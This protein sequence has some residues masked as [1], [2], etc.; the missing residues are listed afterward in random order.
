MKI[1]FP[2]TM[3]NDG[4]Y[5]HILSI[6]FAEHASVCL[7][8]ESCPFSMNL[9]IWNE[10]SKHWVLAHDNAW[11]MCGSRSWVTWVW[12]ENLSLKVVLVLSSSVS[13]GDIH[14]LNIYRRWQ[15][16]QWQQ[17]GHVIIPM[18]EGVNNLTYQGPAKVQLSDLLSW[19]TPLPHLVKFFQSS[20]NLVSFDMA[21]RKNG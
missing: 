20:P 4:I 8:E 3:I 18:P 15:T 6:F 14:K 16:M 11:L 7:V 9:Y 17:K 12:I 19:W 1:Y 5:S 10:I 21:A 2:A 13:P